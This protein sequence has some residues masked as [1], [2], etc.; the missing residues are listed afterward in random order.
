MSMPQWT[1]SP[2]PAGDWLAV[3]DVTPVGLLRVERAP[4]V[5]A[6]Q[7]KRSTAARLR[8]PDDVPEMRF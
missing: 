7:V 4:G 6:E 5:S 8:A 2:E 1:S 3:I